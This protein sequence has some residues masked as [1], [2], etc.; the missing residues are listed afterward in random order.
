MWSK[1]IYKTYED[2]PNSCGFL[3]EGWVEKEYKRIENIEEEMGV[4]EER[5]FLLG[6]EVEKGNTVVDF[7]GSLGLAYFCFQ[8]KKLKYHIIETPHVCD[9]GKRLIPQIKF[10][11]TLPKIKVD[12]LYC[13]TA[14]Q[15]VKDWESTLKGFLD[16]KPKCIIFE[17]LS[18]GNIDS[19][20]GLQHWKGRKVPYW[21]LNMERIKEI[22]N[23]SYDIHLEE[24]AEN[25]STP[26]P[27]SYNIK[28]TQNLILKV[29]ENEK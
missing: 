22:F 24:K 7:G 25:V 8:G 12:I 18:A 23:S 13:R 10:H 1:E 14:L 9:W 2:L 29:K 27:P 4:L 17:H 15:Y 20:I 19:F 16:L 3:D 21:F 5:Y 28:C 11:T 6:Q 26:Y